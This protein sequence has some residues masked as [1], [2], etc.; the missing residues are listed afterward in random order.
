MGK[1]LCGDRVVPYLNY[2]G[3]YSNIYREWNYIYLY[4]HTYAQKC[5]QVKN[6]AKSVV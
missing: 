5:V 6:D 4:T 3:S 1:F 2:G